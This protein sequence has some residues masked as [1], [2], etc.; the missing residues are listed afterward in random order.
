MGS[1]RERRRPALLLLLLMLAAC[2]APPAAIVVPEPPPLPPDQEFTADDGARLPVQVWMPS[3]RI[4]AVILALHGFNDYAHAFA[5]PGEALALRGIATYAYDQRGFGRTPGRGRWAGEERL[6]AD[7]IAMSRWLRTLHPGMPLYLLG[8]SM[9]GAVAVLATAR[10]GNRLEAD[11]LILS[12]PAVWGESLTEIAGRSVLWLGGRLFPGLTLTGRGLDL[13]PSDNIRMLRALS[14]DPLV[15]KA[16]R[17]DMLDGL[18]GLMGD[19]LDAARHLSLPVLVLYGAHDEIVAKAPS[20]LMMETLLPSAGARIAWYA[21]GYH[22]LL[23]DLD[24]AVVVGDIAAWIADPAAPLPSGA[25]RYAAFALAPRRS[26][27]V[28]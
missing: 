19:A 14:R 21:N 1:D 25:D 28:W 26:P 10:G 22:M 13:R 5:P 18:V 15:I 20:L 12:A 2:A 6:A 8:E 23:R 9:G 3:G 24:A 27:E 11:G 4:R 7:A 16:T 17:I